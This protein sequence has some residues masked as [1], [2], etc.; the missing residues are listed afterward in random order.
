MC[1]LYIVVV[2]IADYEMKTKD[3]R[4]CNH[5]KTCNGCLHCS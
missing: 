4:S 2:T 5:S 1:F 3:L